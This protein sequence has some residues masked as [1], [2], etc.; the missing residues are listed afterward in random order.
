MAAQATSKQPIRVPSASAAWLSAKRSLSLVSGCSFSKGP[1]KESWISTVWSSAL[2]PLSLH[3]PPATFHTSIEGGTLLCVKWTGDLQI[4]SEDRPCEGAGLDSCE[5][6]SVTAERLIE[7]GLRMGET[8]EKDE[9]L[10]VELRGNG[11]ES[12]RCFGCHGG[13]LQICLC[14]CVC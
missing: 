7:W 11:V 1:V 8:N 10:H 6:E 12:V 9:F 4:L 13:W 2:S 3:Q 5:G 14:L